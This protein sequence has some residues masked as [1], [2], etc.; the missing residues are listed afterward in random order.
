MEDRVY[1]VDEFIRTQADHRLNKAS[2]QIE[3]F[4]GRI[5]SMLDKTIAEVRRSEGRLREAIQEAA[6]DPSN[7]AMKG[8]SSAKVK[9][10]RMERDQQYRS[11]QRSMSQLPNLVRL[12]DY[13]TVMS[14][15][16]LLTEFTDS[17]RAMFEAK[18]LFTVHVAFKEDHEG[19]VL[20]PDMDRMLERVDEQLFSASAELIKTTPRV[21]HAHTF[22]ELF[23]FEGRKPVGPDIN[24]VIM[25]YK[26]LAMALAKADTLI[27]SS[28]QEAT[29]VSA[30]FDDLKV[31]SKFSGTWNEEEYKSQERDIHQFRKD[32]LLMRT[33][34]NDITNMVKTSKCGMIELDATAM[35]AGLQELVEGSLDVMRHMLITAARAECSKVFTAFQLT[36]KNIARRPADL[37][38]FCNFLEEY[39]KMDATR[40]QMLAE[41][42]LVDEMYAML[43]SYNAKIPEQDRLGLVRKPPMSLYLSLALLSYSPI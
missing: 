17:V 6:K 19:Y 23:E 15:V 20:T 11:V 3:M 37:D 31:I 9:V 33:W 43:T 36:T 25:T 24:S 40:E 2:S 34:S 4:I 42:S 26:P 29:K 32:M 5:N 8:L 12:A 10:E 16:Q 28:Y 14:M 18:P 35:Q 22:R 39:D 38:G 1:D 13:M 41:A 30:V 27:D 21:L 7:G